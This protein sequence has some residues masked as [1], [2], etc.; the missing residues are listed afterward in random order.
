M[1]IKLSPIL[2]PGSKQE[3]YRA[4]LEDTAQKCLDHLSNGADYRLW[5]PVLSS[6][7]TQ[8]LDQESGHDFVIS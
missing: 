7:G 4:K 5:G 6:V 2:Q 1:K 3:I 8:W